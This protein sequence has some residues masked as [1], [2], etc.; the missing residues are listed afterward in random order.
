LVKREIVVADHTGLSMQVTLWGDRAQQDDKLFD[1]GAIVLLQGVLIKEWNGGRSGS[2]LEAGSLAFSP[3][4]PEA[5]KVRLWW[6]T[7]GSSQSL[8]ALSQDGAG[9][10]AAR[11][12]AGR[13]CDIAE[14]RRAAELVSAQPEVFCVIARLAL[15]QMK[16]QGETQPLLYMACQEPKAGTSLPCNKRVGEDGF[17]PAC[18]RVGKAAPRL[19]IRCRFSD[20]SDSAWLTTFH[21]AAQ[22]VL[23]LTAEEAKDIESGDGGREALE[24]RIR[25]RYFHQPLQ[26]SV[27]AKLDTYNGEQRT[28]ITCFDARPVNIGQHGRAMLKG[29]REMLEH[30]AAATSVLGV[31][32]A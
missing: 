3:A 24:N 1:S 31:A 13:A 6:S 22:N 29:I 8:T 12:A 10:A 20:H 16:K 9:G 26:V 2:L 27:R 11:L 25:R 5:E 15:V 4:T 23:C 28:N 18:G 21:E 32:A 17:C 19:N 14:M 30:Q 7:G